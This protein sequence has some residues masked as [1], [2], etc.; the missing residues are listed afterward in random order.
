MYAIH[1]L[2]IH[3]LDKNLLFCLLPLGKIFAFLDFILGPEIRWNNYTFV[4]GK[5]MLRYKMLVWS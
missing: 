4:E 1:K 2:Y 3:V 5:E